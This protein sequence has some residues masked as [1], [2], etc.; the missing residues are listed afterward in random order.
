M[1]FTDK[2]PQA[3]GVHQA[4]LQDAMDRPALGEPL[5]QDAGELAV[6]GRADAAAGGGRRIQVDAIDAAAAVKDRFAGLASLGRTYVG[7]EGQGAKGRR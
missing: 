2:E 5:A 3:R 1:F 6:G 4:T 7:L